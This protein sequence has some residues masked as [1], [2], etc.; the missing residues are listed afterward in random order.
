MSGLLIIICYLM[1]KSSNIYVLT[2]ILFLS[3]HV[4]SSSSLDTIGLE[5]W[6]HLYIIA[7]DGVSS[8][9]LSDR[10]IIPW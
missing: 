7:L 1:P 5:D 4:Y 9:C 3:C 2:L 6:E 8:V 10:G